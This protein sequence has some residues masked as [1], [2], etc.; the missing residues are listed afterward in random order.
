M[1]A[2]FRV[3]AINE[4]VLFLDSAGVEGGNFATALSAAYVESAN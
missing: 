4:D 2:V 3:Q 1:A